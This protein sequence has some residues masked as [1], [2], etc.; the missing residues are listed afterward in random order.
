MDYHFDR[1]SVLFADDSELMRELVKAV[2]SSLGI[3]DVVTA[4]SGR[5]A[6]KK[7]QDRSFDLAIIDWN[8]KPE[9]G[10]D[11]V[12]KVRD[13]EKS[14][15]P[16][17]PVI[18]MTAYSEAE[19]VAEARDAGVTDFLVKPITATSLCEHL[20]A[21]IERPRDYVDDEAYFGPERRH[22][23]KPAESAAPAAA[24]APSSKERRKAPARIVAA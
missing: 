19:R 2:L 13:K 12:R 5:E 16:F 4:K 11:F 9:S 18:M 17:M 23:R 8:M 24:A 14:A 7:F 21:V 22:R 15:D 3:R 20:V 10:I 6:W 1:I